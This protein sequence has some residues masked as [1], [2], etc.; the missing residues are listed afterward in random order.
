MIKYLMILAAMTSAAVTPVQILM[1]EPARTNR[2]AQAW[3]DDN[4]PI[5]SDVALRSMITAPAY[6][7][8]YS[9]GLSVIPGILGAGTERFSTNWSYR[10]KEGGGIGADAVE[11]RNDLT[12]YADPLVISNINTRF[13]NVTN[14]GTY[15][16]FTGESI[17][18]TAPRTSLS[19]VTEVSGGTTV[20]SLRSPV[21]S[22]LLSDLTLS[23]P[24]VLF[25][26]E[27]ILPAASGV[28]SNTNYPP[29]S[30][31]HSAGMFN[32]GD[33]V[34]NLM[35]L[36]RKN[37]GL[38]TVSIL[39]ST[40]MDNLYQLMT[41]PTSPVYDGTD[42]GYYT[43]NNTVTI[44]Y[45][46][47]GESDVTRVVYEEASLPDTS[48]WQAYRDS[49]IPDTARYVS[50]S[51][52][53]YPV[54]V[55]PTDG[56]RVIADW[57]HVPVL[58]TLRNKSDLYPDLE[59]WEYSQEE[60][61][62]AYVDMTNAVYD[63]F[64]STG[65]VSNVIGYDNE[66]SLIAASPSQGLSDD[67]RVWAATTNAYPD[68]RVA[69]S[70]YLAAASVQVNMFKED[71]IIC[72]SDSVSSNGVVN[73][74]RY[75]HMAANTTSLMRVSVSMHFDS[76]AVLSTNTARYWLMAGNDKILTKRVSSAGER[77]PAFTL[78]GPGIPVSG[79]LFLDLSE[80]R[81]VHSNALYSAWYYVKF[82]EL[83]GFDTWQD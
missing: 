1:E 5:T 74:H 70:N 43:N 40:G 72:V 61:A 11:V 67:I 81:Q 54:Y 52:A 34:D 80:M 47:A 29:M 28:I 35:W 83:R 42:S 69:A 27:P 63:I 21:V 75:H 76:G 22:S 10:F 71:G 39:A 30:M 64:N 32:I 73:F 19:S 16:T 48:E 12:S 62:A 68:A 66:A 56:S 8:A 14:R 18:L 45:I 23:A 2:S 41:L 36:I 44:Y 57:S 79:Y 37:T 33:Y 4:T 53:S 7:L 46:A 51:L 38:F 24:A 60:M 20:S 15:G 31:F 55:P 59:W 13:L 9:N 3:L 26:N 25:L 49:H 78:T 82:E 58:T 6:R 65:G 50:G 17:S 77:G